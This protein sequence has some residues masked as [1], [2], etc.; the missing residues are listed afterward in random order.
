MVWILEV[1]YKP[2][3]D[4][5]PYSPLGRCFYTEEEANAFKSRTEQAWAAPSG[6]PAP[7]FRVMKYVPEV[8][9]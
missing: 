7:L 4:W 1:R 6:A 8:L 5:I 2:T 3:E 9:P